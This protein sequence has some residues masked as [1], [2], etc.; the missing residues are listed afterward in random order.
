[1]SHEKL[2]HGDTEKSPREKL[3]QSFGSFSVVLRVLLRVSV[4]RKISS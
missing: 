3:A 4:V 1:M 2:H